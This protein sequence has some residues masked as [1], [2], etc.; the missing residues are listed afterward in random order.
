MV[1]VVIARPLGLFFFVQKAVGQK[2]K[3]TGLG[4]LFERRLSKRKIRTP[5]IC[6]REPCTSC[7]KSAMVFALTRNFSLRFLTQWVL[8]QLSKVMC[9]NQTILI[10]SLNAQAFAAA[11]WL[12]WWMTIGAEAC[13]WDFWWCMVVCQGF[14]ILW[15]PRRLCFALRMLL[16]KLLPRLP[17]NT[18]SCHRPCGLPKGKPAGL[19]RGAWGYTW[20]DLGFVCRLLGFEL[21]FPWLG[22]EFWI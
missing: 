15:S 16:L 12:G 2:E 6:M 10:Q 5:G 18:K 11:I 20:G 3:K 22:Y 13:F 4:F 9:F 17:C 1:V 19:W 8:K 21:G 14:H 7:L